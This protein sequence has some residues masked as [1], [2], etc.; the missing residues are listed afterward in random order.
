MWTYTALLVVTMV[1]TGSGEDVEVSQSGVTTKVLGRSGKITLSKDD[2]SVTVE[3]D[4]LKEKLA[5]GSDIKDNSHKFN[6]FASQDFTF[7]AVTDVDYPDTE[8]GTK[9]ITFTATLSNSATFQIEMYF[10]NEDG[11]ITVGD[12]TSSVK[13]GDVKFNTKVNG[14]TFC[15]GTN[16]CQQSETGAFLDFDI[17]IKGK[18]DKG[19][20]TSESGKPDKLSVGNADVYLSN[21]ITKD[22]QIVDMADDFP[23][24]FTQGSKQIIRFR[25]PKFT[26]SIFYD[27]QIHM[28]GAGSLVASMALIIVATVAAVCKII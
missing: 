8:I 21:K 6:N 27:P 3:F 4:N 16:A 9:K 17:V 10:F 23:Q 20:K 12:E 19:E 13:E 15:D 22:N 1:M 14:W 28:G 18:N 7:S 11:N 5:D 24:V 26:G 25:F 2:S